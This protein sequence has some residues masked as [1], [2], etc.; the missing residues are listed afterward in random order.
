MSTTWLVAVSNTRTESLSRWATYANEPS[1]VTAIPSGNCH[2]GTASM[3]VLSEVLMTKT[4]SAFE[5]ET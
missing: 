4:E 5:S 3:T 1:G 2:T